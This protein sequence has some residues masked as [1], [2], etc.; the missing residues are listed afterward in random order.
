MRAAKS[1]PQVNP[2]ALQDSPPP[3]L[4]PYAVGTM[5]HGTAPSPPKSTSAPSDTNA[6]T[7]SSPAPVTVTSSDKTPNRRKTRAETRRMT[8]TEKGD[9]YGFQKIEQD[10]DVLLMSS[11]EEFKHKN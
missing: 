2:S 10:D 11:L 8:F 9:V 6:L 3:I 5:L 1:G 4:N 7:F